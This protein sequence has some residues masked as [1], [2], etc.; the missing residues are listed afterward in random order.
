[1]RSPRSL[2]ATSLLVVLLACVASILWLDVP[3]ARTCRQLDGR[4]REAFEWITLLGDATAQLVPAGAALLF[5]IL[6]KRCWER[7]L[8]ALFVLSSV[9]ASGLACLAIKCVVGRTRPSLLFQQG[10][11]SF[12]GFEVSARYLSFP[13]GHTTT[14]TAFVVALGLLFPRQR[15]VLWTTAAVIAASRV[16]VTAHYLSDVLFG[17]YLAAAATLYVKSRVSGAAY[18]IFEGGLPRPSAV[19]VRAPEPAELEALK[20]ETTP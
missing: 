9:C 3:I 10:L 20:M 2:T 17:A 13:S 12:E 5:F 8:K 19:S 16:I 4:V 1:M 11:Y 18:G 15:L 7:S 6:V 14:F